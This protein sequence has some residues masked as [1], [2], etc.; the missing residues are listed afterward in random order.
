MLRASR[1]ATSS[2]TSAGEGQAMA[3]YPSLSGSLR[4]L[5]ALDLLADHLDLAV[6]LVRIE[7]RAGDGVRQDVHAFGEEAGAEDHVVDGLVEAGPGVD[8]AAAG[9]DGAGDL[10]RAAPGGPLEQH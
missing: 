2:W 4:I 8:L 1:A 10:A 3:R 7:R 9:L 5:A 6:Q